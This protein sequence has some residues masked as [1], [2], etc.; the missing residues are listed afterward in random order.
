LLA[1]ELS[2]PVRG[3]EPGDT[4]A[5]DENAAFHLGYDHG[6]PVVLPASATNKTDT[7]AKDPNLGVE[8]RKR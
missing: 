5:D 2:D 7:A 6:M 4:S 3:C 1:C 8:E